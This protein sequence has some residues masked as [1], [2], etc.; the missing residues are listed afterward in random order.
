MT[1]NMDQLDE[2]LCPYRQELDGNFSNPGKANPIM[3]EMVSFALICPSVRG[4]N[5]FD[6]TFLFNDQEMVRF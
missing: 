2:E 4:S 6:D 5:A 3:F 1:T